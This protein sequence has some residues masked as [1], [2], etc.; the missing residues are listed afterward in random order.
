MMAGNVGKS[1]VELAVKIFGTLKWNAGWHAIKDKAESKGVKITQI[2]ES[3]LTGA[4]IT[5]P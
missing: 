1:D 5:V 2:P 4:G 3:E